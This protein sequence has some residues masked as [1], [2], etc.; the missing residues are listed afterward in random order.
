[1]QI[2]ESQLK[3]LINEELQIVLKEFN[4]PWQEK[5]KKILDNIHLTVKED[6]KQFTHPIGKIIYNAFINAELPLNIFQNK[7][8]DAD[9]LNE[10][11]ADI[12]EKY[13]KKNPNNPV[14]VTVAY[15]EGLAAGHRASTGGKKDPPV[16][17]IKI[18][19]TDPVWS[20]GFSLMSAEGTRGGIPGIGGHQATLKAIE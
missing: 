4:W 16:I 8:I 12:K 15:A 9:A 13:N 19:G 1:M 7:K 3:R 14:E 17:I 18:T 20:I 5:E 6:H 11:A 2:K 10:V